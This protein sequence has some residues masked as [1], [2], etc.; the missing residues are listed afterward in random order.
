MQENVV[1]EVLTS[2]ERRLPLP[3]A[4]VHRDAVLLQSSTTTEAPPAHAPPGAAAQNGIAK[5]RHR[6]SKGISLA[7]VAPESS[8]TRRSLLPTHVPSRTP[9]HRRIYMRT[10]RQ[11]TRDHGTCRRAVMQV[12]RHSNNSRTAGARSAPTPAPACRRHH[13][14]HHHSTH[15]TSR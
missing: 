15:I 5:T 12:G 14:H 13:H 8:S 1:T 6:Q 2:A 4:M 10:T 11:H 3:S 9:M 7:Q